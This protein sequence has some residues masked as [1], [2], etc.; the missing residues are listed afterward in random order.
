M[1]DIACPECIAFLTKYRE[2]CELYAELSLELLDRASPDAFKT[3]EFQQLKVATEAARG[4]CVRVK[5]ELHS[6][7]EDHGKIHLR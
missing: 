5:A 3:P 1:L 4:K 6:H 7:G 2:A